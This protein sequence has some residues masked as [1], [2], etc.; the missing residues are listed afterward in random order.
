MELAPHQPAPDFTLP[1]QDGASH[2]LS[3][4][5]G[6]WVVLYFY[7]KDDTP[8]CTKEAC[9]FRDAIEAFE[10]R[11]VAILGVSADSETSH[12][13]FAEKYSLPFPLLADPTKNVIHTYHADRVLGTKRMTYLI[14]PRG[15]IQRIYDKVTPATHATDLL[16]E[17]AGASPNA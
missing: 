2:T 4:L 16:N 6:K 13:R 8:G 9:G 3:S 17:I 10:K 12:K 5:R 11:G 15:S 14:D 7:P 1:D